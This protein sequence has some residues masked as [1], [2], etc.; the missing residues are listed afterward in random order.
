[1]IAV[2]R[3]HGKVGL[4]KR[5]KETLDRMRI[6]KKYS[7][8]IL[9][10][11]KENLGM[12]NRVKNQVAFGEI[13]KKTFEKLIETRGQ[14]INKDKKIDFKKVVEEIEKGKSYE[15]L[16]L[17]PFFRLHPPRKGV[18]TKVHFPKGV[19]GNHK[20]KINELILRML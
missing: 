10:P 4:N 20:E 1:M 3:I 5:V 19:L 8:V 13:D 18:K 6:K 12:I 2:I 15:K 17:I 11:T 9:N 16:N 14:K 7:C